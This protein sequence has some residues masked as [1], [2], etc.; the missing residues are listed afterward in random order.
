MPRRYQCL[1]VSSEIVPGPMDRW[2]FIDATSNTSGRYA[3]CANEIVATTNI[4]AARLIGNF[5][6][7]RLVIIDRSEWDCPA[8]YLHARLQT[9]P[10]G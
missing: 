8:V 9:G 7:S 3:V 2:I 4:P 6:A 10:H 1:L 5:E